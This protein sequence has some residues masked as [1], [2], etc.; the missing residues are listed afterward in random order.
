MGG[1]TEEEGLRKRDR[2][3]NIQG[4]GRQRKKR[5]EGKETDIEEK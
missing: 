4:R 2:R 1:E 5:E 3:P